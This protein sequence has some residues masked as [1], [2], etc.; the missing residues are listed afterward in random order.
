M[1]V[2]CSK[3]TKWNQELKFAGSLLNGLGRS[4]RGSRQ[5]KFLVL[6]FFDVKEQQGIDRYRFLS[7]SIVPQMYSS[8]RVYDIEQRVESENKQR[9]SEE[10]RV[11]DFPRFKVS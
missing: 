8:V 4:R 10:N 3:P 2:G 6:R 1:L 11:Q 9:V 5:Q 7:S